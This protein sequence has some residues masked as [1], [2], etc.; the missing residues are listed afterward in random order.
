ML[1]AHAAVPMTGLRSTTPV[2]HLHP[3]PQ[4][5]SEEAGDLT[6]ARRE[7]CD[8]HVTARAEKVTGHE[9]VRL[10]IQECTQWREPQS[11]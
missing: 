10:I 6:L 9:E 5:P 2:C 4:V 11:L 1:E 8:K 3:L 7:S